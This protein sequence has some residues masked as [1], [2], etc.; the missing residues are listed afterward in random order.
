MKIKTARK[1]LLNAYGKTHALSI[2]YC[3]AY[4]LLKGAGLEPFAFC[5]GVYGWN[6]DAYDYKGVLICTGYRGMIGKQAENVGKYNKKAREILDSYPWNPE[7]Y[8]KDERKKK[9]R[10][11]RLL[12]K[13]IKENFKK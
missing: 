4:Y 2:G 12:E 1:N 10:C 6:F 3:D 11:V 8:K 7:T 9:I 13:F 5:S